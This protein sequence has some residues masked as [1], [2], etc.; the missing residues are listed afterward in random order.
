LSRRPYQLHRLGTPAHRKAAGHS[1]VEV[2]G[3]LDDESKVARLLP[4][5]IVSVDIVA[6][7]PVRLK[8][9]VAELTNDTVMAI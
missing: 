6:L 4:A 9:P 7:V 1:R 8:S 3:N 2:L 5:E